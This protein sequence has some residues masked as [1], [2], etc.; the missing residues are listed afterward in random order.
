MFWSGLVSLPIAIVLAI[1]G[2]WC[3]K[4]KSAAILFLMAGFAFTH[5]LWY[6]NVLGGSLGT[7]VGN[8]LPPSWHSF[9]PYGLLPAGG[10]LLFWFLFRNLTV[11]SSNNPG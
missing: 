3:R 8:F 1:V 4:A 7:K 2:A 9:L 6:F 5:F 11:K 10:L